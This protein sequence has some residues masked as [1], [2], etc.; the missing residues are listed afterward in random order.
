MSGFD[1]DVGLQGH[2]QALRELSQLERRLQTRAVRAGLVE[3]VRP[4][5][6]A[7]Q[8]MAPKDSGDLARA[9]GHRSLPNRLKGRLG[10]AAQTVALLVG[11]NRK[12][13]GRWQGRKGLWQEHGTERMEASPFMGPA[14]E[15]GRAGGEQR[16]YKGLSQS[17]ERM[18]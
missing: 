1:L 13:K 4:I 9:V 2:D 3:F 10:I 8:A 14:L 17:L 15:Q 6:S 5:K 18:R 11:P 12:V 7:A 16:F